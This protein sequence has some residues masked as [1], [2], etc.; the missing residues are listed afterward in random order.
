M[1]KRESKSPILIK[2][3]SKWQNLSTGEI[4][5]ATEII[6][7]TPKKAAIFSAIMKLVVSSGNKKMKVVNYIL[8][9]MEKSTCVLITT[10][11]EL[12]EKSGVSYQTVIDTLKILEYYN[13]I[14]RKTGV[15]MVNCD[16]IRDN[17]EHNE[18][19]LLVRF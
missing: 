17:D 15:I 1:P 10:T 8:E 7:R 12:A 4:I 2:D 5:E 16:L 3:K 18:K 9:N 6:E 14:E 19:Y 11:R 13:V